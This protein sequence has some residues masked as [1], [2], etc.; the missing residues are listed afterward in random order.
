MRQKLLR[1]KH[2]KPVESYYSPRKQKRIKILQLT[3]KNIK[4][5]NNRAI[6]EIRMLK[7]ALSDVH[8]QM[9][10]ISDTSLKESLANSGVSDIQSELIKD[11]FAA[12]KI[13]NSKG[14]RYSEN[15]MMLCLL[16][17]IR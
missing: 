6:Q 1:L 10:N 7:N 2:N 9:Q 14:R 5:K 12:A 13:K 17:Q 4:K 11:I 8:L 16:F 15:W 3:Q